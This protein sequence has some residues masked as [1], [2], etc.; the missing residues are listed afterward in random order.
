MN[1]CAL[2]LHLTNTDDLERV[3]IYSRT[4]VFKT[5]LCFME[6]GVNQHS[7]YLNLPYEG[8]VGELGLSFGIHVVQSLISSIDEL[9]IKQYACHFNLFY[10][11]G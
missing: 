8:G 5:L 4:H 2:H 1:Q 10:G 7:L 6:K 3:C 11:E 9:E